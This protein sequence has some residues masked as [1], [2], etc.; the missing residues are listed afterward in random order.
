MV[1]LQPISATSVYLILPSQVVSICSLQRLALYWFH[2]PGLLLDKWSFAINEPATWN[3]LPPALQSLDLSENAFKRA[4]KIC[5]RPPGA[6]ETSSWFWCRIQISKLT[7]LL[8]YLLLY[9]V[10]DVF[11]NHGVYMFRLSDNLVVDATMAGGPA[12]Y[13]NHSCHP[14]C[15][16]E[17]VPLEKDSKIIII[18]KRKITQGEEVYI[19]T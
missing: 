3:H 10:I 2:A 5:S 7:Y 8:T 12:R 16:A 6:I 1:S 19:T 9:C 18:T 15:V 11:Q 17:V 4:L 13:I 14:N